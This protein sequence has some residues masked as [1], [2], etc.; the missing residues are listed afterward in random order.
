MMFLE[1]FQS[2]NKHEVSK[3]MA[4]LIVSGRLRKCMHLDI[5][6]P[7]VLIATNLKDKYR[8]ACWESSFHDSE[9]QICLID[10]FYYKS[11]KWRGPYNAF[12]KFKNLT[13]GFVKWFTGASEKVQALILLIV[14]S[15]V[16]AFIFAML[17][18]DIRTELGKLMMK[19]L[20]WIL[21]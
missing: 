14:F 17:P 18:L 9:H 3:E 1:D 5:D 4:E 13:A 8:I 10:C 2:E 21:N 15:M 11:A 12:Y 20:K 16:V 6:Y 19:G 7:R